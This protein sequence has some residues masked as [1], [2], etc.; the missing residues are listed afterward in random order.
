MRLRRGGECRVVNV[1][2]SGALLEGPT[3]LEPGRHVDVTLVSRQGPAMVR[4][5]V[6]RAFVAKVHA[7]AV[8]YQAAIRFDRPIAM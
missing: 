5:L 8:V 2:H 7:E 4:A 6:V 3:R 1:S